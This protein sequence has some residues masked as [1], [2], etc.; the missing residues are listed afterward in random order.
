MK[1]PARSLKV[2]IAAHRHSSADFRVLYK[3]TRPDSSEI[4]QAYELFPGYANMTD[5]DGDGFGDTIISDQLNNG[6][7]D[8]IV[9]PNRDD[10]FS[11]Y[12]F[13]ADD[14][15]EFT[16]F[17]I[18]IVSSGSDEANPPRYKDLRVLALA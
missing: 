11:E 15:E 14:L 13:T 7:P 1:Q 9:N 10:E 5:R 6:T 3:L 18:K 12:Q 4:D 16:G 17:K 2:L 8:A